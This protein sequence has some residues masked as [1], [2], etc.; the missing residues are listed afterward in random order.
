MTT[1]DRTLGLTIAISCAGTL[2]LMVFALP[3]PSMASPAFARKQKLACPVCHTAFPQLNATGR[4]F[5]ENGYR[6]PDKEGGVTTTGLDLGSGIIVDPSP[7]LAV[8][9]VGQPLH[10]GAEEGGE[11]ELGTTPLDEVEVIGLGSSGDHWSFMAHIEAGAEE[12]FSPMIMGVVQ[13]RFTRALNAFGGF[14]TIF[15]RD[16]YNSLDPERRLDHSGHAALDYTGSSGVSLSGEGAQVGLDGRAGPVFWM[17]LVTPGPEEMEGMA[18]E[19][20]SE[21]GGMA[22]AMTDPLDYAGRVAINLSKNV[23]V[24][25]LTYAAVMEDDTTVRPGL[26]FNAYMGNHTLQAV[27]LYDTMDSAVMAELGWNATLTS[28]KFWTVPLAR[29]DLT[30]TSASTLMA[31]T[32]GV[33]LMQAGGRLSLEV[34]EPIDSS[35][36]VGAPN[37]RLIVDAVF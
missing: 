5:L 10:Y 9:L 24:G 31:P 30:Q 16:I 19:D 15:S 35:E 21:M 14:S 23:S 34:S 1:S 37:A 27:F 2:A 33:G 8:R 7:G 11:A 26:D 36:S 32:V 18:T 20:S 4:A 3:T 28:G 13:Y 6:M 22:A 25:A 17:A 12:G 29:F